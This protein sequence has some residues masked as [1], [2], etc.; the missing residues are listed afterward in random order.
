MKFV[1]ITIFLSVVEPAF[2]QGIANLKFSHLTE[3]EGLSNNNVISIASDKEGIIWLGTE[4]GL[5]RFD[6]YRVKNFYSDPHEPGAI[7]NNFISQI[8]PDAKNNLWISCSE[9]IY[10]FNTRSQRAKRFG[11]AFSDTNSFRD[12]RRPVIYL[13]SPRLPWI[14]TYDGLYQFSDSTHYVR[15]NKGLFAYS[16]MV[17]KEESVHSDFIKDKAGGLWCFWENV[18]FRVNNI[19]KELIQTYKCSDP[20][21]ITDVFFDSRNRC[22]ISTWGKGIYQLD[23]EKGLWQ[24]LTSAKGL[25]VVLGADEWSVN[26]KKMI[27]FSEAIQGLIFVNEDNLNTSSYLFD[28]S[29]LMLTGRPFVDRQNILWIISR[30]GVYYSSSSNNLFSIIPVPPLKNAKGKGMSSFVY[31][32]EEEKSGYWISKRYNGGLCEYDKN[33]KLINAWADIPVM[34]TQ[35][36]EGL[37]A[38]SGEVFDFKQAGDNM[39]MTTEGGISVLN[40]HSLRWTE[41]APADVKSSPRLRT[42]IEEN[43]HS[44]WIRSFDQ[45]VFIFNPQT[46]VFTKHYRSKD[47]C[48]GCLQGHMNYLFRDKQQRI[49]ACTINGL[50]MYDKQKDSFARFSMPGG[51]AI[52][53]ILYGAVA[54][55]DGLLWIGAENGLFTLNPVNGEIEK[56]FTTNNKIGIVYRICPDKDQN[57]WFSSNS[58]YWCWLRKPEK[59]IHFEYSLG[60]AKTDGEIFYN[61]SD[62][63]MYAGAEDAIVRF[64]PDFLMNYKSSGRANIMEATMHDSL[65]SFTY[66]AAGQKE[67]IVSPDDNNISIDFDVINYDLSG[68]NQFYYKLVPGDHQWNE[69]ES[70]HLAFYNLQ[71]GHYMLQVKGASKLNGDFTNIDSLNIIV[72]KYWYQQAWFKLFSLLLVCLVIFFMVRYRIQRIRKEGL[73]NERIART[74]MAALRAQMSPHFIFNSLNS[75]ENFMMQNERMLAIDY[76]NKFATLIRMILENGRQQVVPVA[77]DMEAMQLYVDLEKIR[78]ENKFQYVTD[79]DRILLTGDYRIPPLLIQPFVENAII[80]G[81]APSGRKDL[82]LRISVKHYSDLVQY[83]I[84]DNGIGRAASAMYTS[85]SKNSHKSLGLKISQERID[86]I[87]A[88]NKNDAVLHIIDLFDEKKESAGTRVVLTL[89]ID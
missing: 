40:L 52:S 29:K 56:D 8:V 69:S 35:K 65:V 60:L 47:S 70:G 62:G 45:G 26:G 63:Y 33:W 78:F 23:T 31:N 25:T 28:G 89:K 44:W 48:A 73:T 17:K 72:N 46:R 39:F 13:D 9:G 64:Y 82:F 76:L 16:A 59:L 24:P 4:N 6:G 71:P 87:N 2:S 18:V 74:E 54:D 37:D 88:R 1:W 43:D 20:I 36:F 10:Y 75:I 49:F 83:T 34:G 68:T 67:L 81:I 41:Y 38:T 30:E 15:T 19:T 32:M 84:E 21:V 66:S 77:T 57:M 7:P 3:K 79:I 50:F 85:K 12:P 58:G 5:N 42:I 80:H 61:A 14:V 86:M 55:N 53:P 27:V 22:W 51:S 11:P